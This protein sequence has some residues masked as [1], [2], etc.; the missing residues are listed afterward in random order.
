VRLQTRG[1]DA[2]GLD[3]SEYGETLRVFHPGPLHDWT[4]HAADA[5]RYLAM[6]IDRRTADTGFDRRIVYPR[7]GVA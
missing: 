4:S 6:T 5:F 1:I 2:L 7:V 3:R